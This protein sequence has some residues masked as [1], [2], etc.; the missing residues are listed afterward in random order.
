MTPA[1]V[2]KFIDEQ[3]ADAVGDGEGGVARHIFVS[4]KHPLGDVSDFC[5]IHPAGFG[6]LDL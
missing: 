2:L 5:E 3:M 4:V 6:E 1:G